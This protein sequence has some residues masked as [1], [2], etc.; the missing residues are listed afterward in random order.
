[1]LRIQDRTTLFRF[2]IIVLV[3]F[4][5]YYVGSLFISR[6]AV[7]TKT[8]EDLVY[9]QKD[10]TGGNKHRS[11][12]SNDQ[13]SKDVDPIRESK[14]SRNFID[15]L[16]KKWKEQFVALKD[17]NR[18]PVR[19]RMSSSYT[20]PGWFGFFGVPK[21]FTGCAVPCKPYIDDKE[22]DFPHDR[23]DLVLLHTPDCKARG[24]GDFDRFEPKNSDRRFLT[25]QANIRN[26]NDQIEYRQCSEVHGG[27][28]EFETS[29]L[30]VTIGFS[31]NST[32]VGNYYYTKP[33]SFVFKEKTEQEEKEMFQ[34][35]CAFVSNCVQHRVDFMKELSEYVP[36]KS[37]G[38][39]LNN[40]NGQGGQNFKLEQIAKCKFYL[41]FENN[42]NKDYI[43]EKFYQGWM[44]N[45]PTILVYYGAPN[46]RQ[47]QPTDEY[48]SFIDTSQFKS[49]KEL[50]TY[51]KSLL[52]NP[53]EY[54]K[55]FEWRKT[56]DPDKDFSKKFLD[57]YSQRV[58][59][60]PCKMCVAAAEMQLARSLLAE[61]GF[62][63][64]PGRY[65]IAW[66]TF[67]KML[68]YKDHEENEQD[69]TNLYQIAYGRYWVE[70]NYL[71]DWNRLDYTTT[72]EWQELP[73]NSW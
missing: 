36:L 8:Q 53:K 15:R 9:Y 40:A 47:V 51:M 34:G 58:I 28:D 11:D 10:E 14:S 38:S 16:P 32:V 54:N 37:F 3:C 71:S 2:V 73:N 56:G 49:V 64:E 30:D 29:P 69:I 20:T 21:A 25:I 41:A 63:P 44:L 68:K 33:S 35:M 62:K 6:L 52:D 60:V 59:N 7:P 19:V 24:Q 5:L 70:D 22:V 27:V 1:M 43:T 39:C 13:S 17:R 18:K 45:S 55:Y 12:R 42:R 31:R 65:K 48:P 23:Y 67:K 4:N 61:L 26:E 72:E 50:G 66:E 46:I 57:H